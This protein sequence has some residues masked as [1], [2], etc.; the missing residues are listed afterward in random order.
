MLNKIIKI[1]IWIFCEFNYIILKF[2]MK[3]INFIINL[4]EIDIFNYFFFNFNKLKFTSLIFKYLIIVKI[5]DLFLYDIITNKE[6]YKQYYLYLRQKAKAWYY[7]AI[8][9]LDQR[10]AAMILNIIFKVK[11]AYKK[12]LRKYKNKRKYKLMILYFCVKFFKKIYKIYSFF[13]KVWIKYKL[14]IQLFIINIYKFILNIYLKSKIYYLL[15]FYLI[16]IIEYFIYI[17]IVFIEKNVKNN[18]KKVKIR[19]FLKKQ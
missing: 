13:I 8:N 9:R 6:Y 4:Y 10:F 1:C 15:F 14:K 2:I 19:L 16:N 12:I 5:I 11:K 7:G 17:L 18:G 3:F